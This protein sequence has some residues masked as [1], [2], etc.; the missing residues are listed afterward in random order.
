MIFIRKLHIL[1][2]VLALV[3]FLGGTITAGENAKMNINTATAEDLMSLKGVAL[4]KAN[5]IIAYRVEKG[6]FTSIDDIK[7][8]KGI[9]DK[10]FENI[11]DLITVEEE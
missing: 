3:S 8:V 10:I 4:K 11:K 2:V 1:L 5:A 9:G 6:L 7:N